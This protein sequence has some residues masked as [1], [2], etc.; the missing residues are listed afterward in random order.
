MSCT[1]NTLALPDLQL[2]WYEWGTEFASDATYLLVHATGFHARCWDKTIAA[3]P[4]RHVVALDMRGH[5]LSSKVAPYDWTTF[6]DDLRHFVDELDLSRLVGVGHSMG[7]H[8]VTQLAADEPERFERLV[9]VDPVIMSPELYVS[10]KP[11]HSA[12]LNAE[13]LHP[14]A[15]RRNLFAN[16]QAMFDNFHGRGSYSTWRDAILHDYCE[17]GLIKNPDGEGFVLACPPEVEAAIYMGNTGST[18]H[19]RLADVTH[20]VKVLRARQRD[21][22]GEQMDFSASP[23]WPELASHFPNGVDVFLPELTH[24][25]PMQAPEFLGRHII[26]QTFVGDLSA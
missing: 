13:G 8:C 18:I 3:M 21:Q 5:G 1:R 20:P 12:W 11:E 25:M 23:T 15:R 22:L 2:C 24:F 26:E 14:V 9:L 4:D 17:Y 6:G 19:E 10:G 7:G 16:A